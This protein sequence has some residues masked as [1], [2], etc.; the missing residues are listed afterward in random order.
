M[1]WSLKLAFMQLLPFQVPL[2]RVSALRKAACQHGSSAGDFRR[3]ALDAKAR[4]LESLDVR[5]RPL[6][7]AQTPKHDDRFQ[8]IAFSIR[9]RIEFSLVIQLTQE[10]LRQS[11]TLKSYRFSQM[12]RSMSH[13]A[14]A[15]PG[16]TPSDRPRCASDRA[17]PAVS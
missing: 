15:A 1:V 8:A 16:A 13:P 14:A 2:E 3:F 7:D 10:V 17:M 11:Q 9:G 12:W 4:V 6:N 5:T